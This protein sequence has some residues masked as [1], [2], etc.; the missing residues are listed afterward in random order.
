MMLVPIVN[1]YAP[2]APKK[3]KY[4]CLTC[5]REFPAE[6]FTSV[7]ITDEKRRAVMIEGGYSLWK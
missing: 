7:Q 4:H 1:P 3:R 2:H 6:N 5:K